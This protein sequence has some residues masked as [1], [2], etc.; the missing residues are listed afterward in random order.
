[1][2]E[3]YNIR[4]L[5]K[6]KK[7]LIRLMLFWWLNW[8]ALYRKMERLYYRKRYDRFRRAF[9]YYTLANTR[10]FSKVK[11]AFTEFFDGMKWTRDTWYMLWDAISDPLISW[12]LGRGDCDDFAYASYLKL[13]G[14]FPIDMNGETIN[15]YFQGFWVCN[16][17]SKRRG[18][19]IAVWKTSDTIGK[20]IVTSNNEMEMFDSVKEILDWYENMFWDIDYVSLVSGAFKVKGIYDRSELTTKL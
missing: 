3:V 5:V 7:L 12:N 2:L 6:M 8:S 9:A 16:N 11:K 13:G 15:F 17:W 20:Y 19:V 10:E 18:H 1:V 14:I 4:S